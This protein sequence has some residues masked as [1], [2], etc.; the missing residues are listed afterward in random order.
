MIN[1]ENEMERSH[2]EDVI[3]YFFHRGGAEYNYQME[4]EAAEITPVYEVKSANGYWPAACL[5]YYAP[6]E[7]YYALNFAGGY[8]FRGTYVIP[9][10]KGNFKRAKAA[11]E[12]YAGDKLYR[13]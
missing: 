13:G 11:F 3:V 5:L 9:S 8:T 4:K 12:K 6:T 2:E 10:T 1:W 7:T